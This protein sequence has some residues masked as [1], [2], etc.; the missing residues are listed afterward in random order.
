LIHPAFG[1]EITVTTPPENT[2]REV[3]VYA[4]IDGPRIR[5]EFFAALAKHY[6]FD[7]AKR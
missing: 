1:E 5:E 2:P 6:G 7:W 3:Q 4:R